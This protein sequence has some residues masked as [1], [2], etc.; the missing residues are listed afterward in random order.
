MSIELHPV[1]R[2]IAL[3]LS[4]QANVSGCCKDSIEASF[5]TGDDFKACPERSRR[6]PQNP[7]KKKPGFTRS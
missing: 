1:P 7:H 5:V 6:V 3:E 2:V 4:G